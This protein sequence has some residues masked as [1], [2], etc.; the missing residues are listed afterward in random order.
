[1]VKS[2]PKKEPRAL[3]EIEIGAGK[4]FICPEPF[5]HSYS[6]DLTGFF[7]AAFKTW[8]LTVNNAIMK[9]SIPANTNIHQ[10]ISIR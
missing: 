9:A 4:L 6:N 1:M 7:L 2:T 8:K 3:S 5:F 10:L